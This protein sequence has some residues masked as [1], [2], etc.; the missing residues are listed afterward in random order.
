MIDPGNIPE[1]AACECCGH[2]T[3]VEELCAVPLKHKPPT[4]PSDP[5]KWV[6]TDCYDKVCE[7]EDYD[8]QN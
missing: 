1:Y 5:E 4:G 6:C 2:S 8:P 3:H 7:E